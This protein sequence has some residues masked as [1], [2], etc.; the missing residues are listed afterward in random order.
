MKDTYK[1]IIKHIAEILNQ[2]EFF[3]TCF[4]T[5]P[6][7]DVIWTGIWWVLA[8]TTKAPIAVLSRLLTVVPRTGVEPVRHCCHWCLRPAR[9]IKIFLFREYRGCKMVQ[10]YAK[11]HPKTAPYYT[12][13]FCCQNHFWRK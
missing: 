1:I 13:N 6:H 5:F 2:F 12:M 3:R 8:K 11:P 7:L 9:I 10:N 4:R